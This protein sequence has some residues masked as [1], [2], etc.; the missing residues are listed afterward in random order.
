MRNEEQ[1]NIFKKIKLIDR[2]VTIADQS[3]GICYIAPYVSLVGSHNRK[4]TFINGYLRM[5][6]LEIL[7]YTFKKP[8]PVEIMR[9][10]GEEHVENILYSLQKMD[11]TA[12]Q[13]SR[14]LYLSRSSMSRLL[15]RLEDGLIL[16]SYT[17]G[18]AR[19]FHINYAYIKEA[20]PKIIKY[21]DELLYSD[22]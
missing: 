13:L 11:K 8:I 21:L 22:E 10:L 4:Y 12:S 3:F 1:L 9:F 14:E 19:Y 18:I 6:H 15:Q 17:R 16:S 20:K 2:N 5:Q 7:P